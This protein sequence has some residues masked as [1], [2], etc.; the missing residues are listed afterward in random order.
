MATC[1]V[2]VTIRTALST[3]FKTLWAAPL[4]STIAPCACRCDSWIR[5]MKQLALAVNTSLRTDLVPYLVLPF[6]FAIHDKT[7]GPHRQLVR[8]MCHSE[9]LFHSLSTPVR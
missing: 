3:Q 6:S 7:F 4:L 5:I 9:P 2:F 8:R 1:S